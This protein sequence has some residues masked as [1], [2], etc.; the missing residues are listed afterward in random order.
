LSLDALIL[1]PGA[2]FKRLFNVNFQQNE[3]PL[4]VM[5]PVNRAPAA[6]VP[7]L[8]LGSFSAIGFE[9]E[10]FDWT[11]QTGYQLAFDALFEKYKVQRVGV[12]PGLYQSGYFGVRVEDD[13]LVDDTGCEILTSFDRQLTLIACMSVAS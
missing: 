3:R 10:V 12:E 1:I 11:D 6:V 9:G 4:V 8:E 2:N 5:V 7:N 13:I